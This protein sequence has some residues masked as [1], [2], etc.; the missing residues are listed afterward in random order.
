[1]K[2]SIITEVRIYYFKNSY[3]VDTSFLKIL[4]RYK[5]AFGSICL[6]SRVVEGNEESIKGLKNIDSEILIINIGT[7]STFVFNKINKEY[8]KIIK[9]SDLIVL[10]LPSVVSIKVYRIIKN[11]KKKYLCEIMGCA[12][13][14]Y[15]NHGIIGKIIAIPMYLMI[16]NIIKK[17]NYCL[18]VTEK[19]LQNRYP[20][21]AYSINAS[22]V[23]I[24]E[25][26]DTKNYNNFDSQNITLF[27]AAAL[28]VKYKGQQFVIKA[29]KQLKKEGINVNYY[30]AGKGD[31]NY[32]LKVARN[33]NVANNVH[34]LGMLKKDEVNNMMLTSDIYIQPSLQEGLPRAVI[35][36]MNCGLICMGANTAGIP[37]LLDKNYI[38]K[39]KSSNAIVNC[40]KRALNDNPFVISN[41]N[42]NEAKKYRS[43]LLDKR[44][45]SFYEKIIRDFNNENDN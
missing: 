37:E 41:R 3:Y 2:V 14:A 32:L 10:R 27:T 7:I 12:F 25:P 20:T 8:Y 42:T 17:A 39:R 34:F 35:E 26:K 30:L 19:F 13:D 16:R 38:F 45:N 4:E 24:N 43:D 21:N 44:R 11:E 31:N 6:F 18:Y 9:E 36:A 1:M 33:N 23:N 29:I 22:N 28:N 5:K 40:I 15:W